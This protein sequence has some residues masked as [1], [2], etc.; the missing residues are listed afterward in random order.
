MSIQSKSLEETIAIIKQ[1]EP[2]YANYTKL[3]TD[4]QWNVLVAISKEEVV[5]YPTSHAFLSKHQ[6][7]SASS[8][9]SALNQLIKKEIV[10]QENS[11]FKVHDILLSRWIQK[12]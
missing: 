8:I 2:I 11:E 9:K 1:E 3:L 12:L 6:L 4:L 10:I 7:G 5:K